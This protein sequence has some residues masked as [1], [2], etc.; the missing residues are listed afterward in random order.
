M[1]AAQASTRSGQRPVP[2]ETIRER[3]AE[4]RGRTLRLV[5]PI[6]TDNLERVHNKLM[7]PLVWDL[8]HIAAYE[9]LWL[10]HRGGGLPVL[11]PELISVYDATETPRCSRGD[12]PLL[13]LAGALDYM[14]DVR[15]RTLTVLKC[16]D[17]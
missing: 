14:A 3:L 9:D 7:S 8:G 15:A 5:A 17:L 2:A 12:L 1:S 6:S 13:G 11:R 4:A 16:V 10:C